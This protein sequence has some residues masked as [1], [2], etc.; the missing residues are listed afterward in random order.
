MVASAFVG[1]LLGLALWSAL[2]AMPFWWA[3]QSRATFDLAGV[4]FVASVVLGAVL[5]SRRSAVASQ[6]QRSPLSFTPR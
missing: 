5:G 1:G 3:H 6:E 4:L 2:L